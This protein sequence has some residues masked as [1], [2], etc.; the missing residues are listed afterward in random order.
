M[1]H[2]YLDQLQFADELGFDGVC[3]N[4]HHSNG[5]ALMS[6]PQMM[7]TVLARNTSRAAIVILGTSIACYDPPQRIAEDM[8]TGRR[9][10]G[11]AG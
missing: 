1:Y 9:H 8:A 7:A 3:V 6:T 5:Y 11:R 10:V 4:E 2:E